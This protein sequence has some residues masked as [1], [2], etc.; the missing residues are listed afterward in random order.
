[1]H[2]RSQRTID[3]TV[4]D[5]QDQLSRRDRTNAQ[6]TSD[7]SKAEEKASNLLTTIEELQGSDSTNQL[8][9]RR[10]ERE[11]RE[12]KER[13][14]RAEKELEGWKGLRMDAAAAADS[15]GIGSTL[16][17]NGSFRAGS[18]LGEIGMNGANR[19]GGTVGAIDENASFKSPSTWGKG[20]VNMRPGHRR[21]GSETPMPRAL[22]EVPQRKAS[23]E[24]KESKTKGFL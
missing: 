8:A 5:L 10:A 6:L 24:R 11:L 4:R 19:G 9:A 13:C 2:D 15:S 16:R 12:A 3:R 22:P 23:L 21:G 18:A 14:L 17:R 7:I 20:S 1:M